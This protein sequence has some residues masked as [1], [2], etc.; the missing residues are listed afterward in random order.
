MILETLL[1]LDAQYSEK[2]VGGDRAEISETGSFSIT[3]ELS[4]GEVLER[5][6]RDI[7]AEPA[8]IT[9]IMDSSVRDNVE[10]H[11]YCVKTLRHTVLIDG[12]EYCFSF[13][14]KEG[15]SLQNVDEKVKFPAGSHFGYVRRQPIGTVAAA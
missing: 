10:S 1:N 14:P 3:E 11:G 6:E 13:D 9:Q 8:S 12:K 7:V 2:E 15:I 5:I 4:F